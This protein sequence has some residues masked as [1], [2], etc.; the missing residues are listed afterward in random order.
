MEI[1]NL[2]DKEFKITIIQMLNE[3]R[4][5][6]DEHCEKLNKEFKNIKKQIELKNT[7]TYKK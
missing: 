1:S 2:P 6:T 3:I 5:R 4:R 7:I